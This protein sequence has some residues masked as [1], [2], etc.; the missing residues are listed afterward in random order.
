MANPAPAAVP[1]LS[2]PELFVERVD[3]EL[4]VRGH[5]VHGDDERLAVRF[6]GREESQ[7]FAFI[8]LSTNEGGLR[9]R[10]R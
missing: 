8:L 1:A 5:A 4:K 3:I 2:P 6:A 7:H 9:Q 10:V